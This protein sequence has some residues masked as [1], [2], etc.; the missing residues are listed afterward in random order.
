[1]N[2]EPVRLNEGLVE[3]VSRTYAWMDDLEAM[4]SQEAVKPATVLPWWEETHPTFKGVT[5]LARNIWS[6]QPGEKKPST[7]SFYIKD[8]ELLIHL[9]GEC[10]PLEVISKL[11]TLPLS[12]DNIR[13][14]HV[15]GTLGPTKPEP[16]VVFHSFP[17]VKEFWFDVDGTTKNIPSQHALFEHFLQALPSVTSIF[18]PEPTSPLLSMQ[19]WFKTPSTV[20]HPGVTEL[21]LVH[22]V[23]TNAHVSLK[24]VQGRFPNVQRFYQTVMRM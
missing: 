22:H 7:V 2:G 4:V 12:L 16:A 14:I 9:M 3:E 17:D 18:L 8:G 21:H 24:Q 11:I 1:M 5:H 15:W 6:Y 10:K 19:D 20:Q 23:D 13:R